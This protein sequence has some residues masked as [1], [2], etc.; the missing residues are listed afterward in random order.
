M[1]AIHRTAAMGS[2]AA[3]SSHFGPTAAIG[4]E[5]DQIA[6]R[7]LFSAKN[8]PLSPNAVD[9]N[10]NPPVSALR[11]LTDGRNSKP[12]AFSR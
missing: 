2:Q 6:Q 10:T 9:H 3:L 5:A 11:G 12:V 7:F 1:H 8:L 4:R